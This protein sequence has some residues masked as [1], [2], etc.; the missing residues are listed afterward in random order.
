MILY[1][2]AMN[3]R[4]PLFVFE[5]ANNHMGDVE[6][7]LRTIR[8]FHDVAT[9]FPE[10]RFAFKLQYRDLDTFIHP[11]PGLR[12][13]SRYVKRF[14]ETRLSD[15]ELLRLRREIGSLGYTAI[16][17]PFDEASVDRIEA[18]GFDVIKVGSC[19][20][21]DW[22]L[23]ERVVN[24][25]KPVIAST[26]GASLDE[27]DRVVSFFQHRNKDLSLMHCVA[28]YPCPE[29]DLQ[30]DQIDLLR[31]RYPRL[32]IGFSTHEPPDAVEPVKLA[33]AKGA[34]I[35]EKHVG[36]ATESYA[37]N[38][39]S[40]SPSQVR[41][42]LE[43]A[44]HAFRLC[45]TP[46]GR[47]SPSARETENLRELRRGVFAKRAIASGE[48]V[49]A[50]NTFLAIP[51]TPGQ[52]TANDMSKYAL[53]TATADLSPA[54]PV[55]SSAVREKDIR[56][57][58]HEIVAH[59]RRILKESRTVLPGQIDLEISHHYGIDR[60]YEYGVA[61]MTYVNRE[62]CKKVIVV[63]PG[64]KHPEQF[65]KV[66]EETFHLVWGDVTVALD[67]K[68]RVCKPGDIV[69]IEREMRHAFASA[70][71]AVIEELSSTHHGEDSYY[72]DEAI[73]QNRDRKTY[74]TYW[75]D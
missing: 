27:L 72:T 41:R 31:D 9:G 2:P 6:H 40:A 8:E 39:Y 23:L 38:P 13:T 5:L 65:H 47:Y 28:E 21:T 24:V 36:V 10:F 22:P 46:D 56:A 50:S 60:F 12:A 49:D 35:F 64:Q 58:V 52:L 75:L 33:V 18:H 59:V 70:G 63:L 7:G 37:M 62:Y 44:R 66:K 74:L 67:G 19:S 29:D 4:K 53:W 16:C 61:M 55:F 45:G 54:Q 71:G 32:P 68:E 1:S 25:N 11:D 34:A 51:T 15:E 57:K 26:A 17:T 14:C 30:L 3:D 69:L 42:W 73:G 20:V 48:R 43:A